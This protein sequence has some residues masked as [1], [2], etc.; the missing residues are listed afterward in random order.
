MNFDHLMM[1]FPIAKGWGVAAGV[2][3][4]SNGYYKIAESVSE[5]DPD[6]DPL[7]GGYTRVPCRRRRLYQ[8]L[9]WNR[10]K[11]Y[12]EFLCWNKYV[13]ALW[14]DQQDQISLIFADYYNVFH[15]NSY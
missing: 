2:V 14:T 3:P 7:T 12:K 11:D 10:S 6:Y 13:P 4:L 8:F 1:G 9:S 15:N 5:G